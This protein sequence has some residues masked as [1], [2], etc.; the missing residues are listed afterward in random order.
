MIDIMNS[1][2]LINDAFLE[3]STK[4]VIMKRMLDLYLGKVPVKD[5]VLAN[6]HKVNNK[7]ANDFYGTIIDDKVGYMGNNIS[8]I[9]DSA[10][11]QEEQYEQIM[12]FLDDWKNRN[13]IDD[14][15]ADTIK[16][17]SICGVAGRL[18]YNSS[19]GARIRNVPNPWEVY[20]HYN[21]D[22][23]DIEY[24]IWFYDKVEKVN[25]LRVTNQYAELYDEKYMYLYKRVG[26]WILVDSIIHMFEGVPLF[27]IPNNSEMMGDYQKAEALIDAYDRAISDGSSEFEQL[28]LAYAVLKGTG[29]QIDEEFV[30]KMK[31]TGILPLPDG[32][33]FTFVSKTIDM[34]AIKVLLDEIRRNIFAFCKSIDFSQDLGGDMRVIGWQTK[35]MPLEN[36][37]KITERK[38]ISALRYQYKLLT[39][40]WK[41]FSGIDLNYLDI[42]WQFVRNIPRDIDS[43]AE[44][45]GK[46]SGFVSQ[47][48]ALSL[49]SFIDNPEKEMEKMAREREVIDLDNITS[50][51]EDRQINNESGSI[52]TATT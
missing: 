10:N 26:N 11:Y 8:V 5:R 41:Q 27:L 45:L 25:G 1:I 49:M 20:C 51:E 50:D 28:R 33:D 23:G 19:E 42:S 38:F 17:A 29:V 4:R 35:L 21:D 30:E 32:G 15:N 22:T 39:A 6:V 12:Q 3:S 24:A 7:L 18:L 43:E 2:E 47:S 52:P 44:T 13:D 34:T 31:Q 48:T 37:C 40:Y 16:Y 14:L 46:L 9:V 36:K